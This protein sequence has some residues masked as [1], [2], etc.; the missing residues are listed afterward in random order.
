MKAFTL[1]EAA[2]AL[3]LP[4]MQ[5]QATL[6]DVCTDTRKIQPGSLF[7]CLRGERFDGHSFASQAAQL[8]AAALL[9]DHPV[10]ADVPQLVV[11]DTGKALL[12]L[13]GWYRRRFQLPV[14]GL[15][16]SVGK[17][18]TKEFIAL[19]LGAKYNTLKT[20]GNLNNEIGVPQML[21]R[22]EDSHTAAVIEM[23]MNHFGEISRLTRAVAPTVGLI[24]NIG[25]SHIENLGSRAGILQAKLEILEGMAPDA[26]LIVNMDND[27]LRTVKLGD[28]PLLTFA[29]DDQ[30]A[31][32][33]ATDIA[34]QG[35][36]TTFTVHHSAFTQPVTI[37]TVGIHN[38]YNALAAMAV[39]YVTGVDPAAAAS[40]LANY[41]PAG[42]RQNLVQV[43]GVQV[44]E[45][46]YNASPDSMRAALQTLGK[47]PV[48]RRYAVLGAMLE[49][50]DYAKE[51]HTQVGKMAAENGID[52][53]LAYGAD[54][55]YIVE[56]AK[57]AG[58]ENARLFDTKEALA[59][60]LAQQVQPGDGVLFKG[61]RGMHLE[62][63]M[64]TVYERWEKA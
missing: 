49:L 22:L 3:G 54:A 9:V 24:T 57:Q 62:D 60:S 39:G 48:R 34:E 1:Q 45:D 33:T 14:V 35:S 63:V 44:I 31:D 20:Q 18:T 6:A 16:G 38:V 19:V 15:T 7:V 61:S 17:T 52:G 51:A 40:A 41:V 59:Q 56:A 12:Q 37:P 53:V 36:T 5:A 11:T 42:M 26:P 25:V 4:Q 2:A 32:F 21:F 64:H 43:G 28:R 8:G 13:A 10:D 23:G 46:C 47:L 58:L 50:G 27:M 55:A 29:I 30:S